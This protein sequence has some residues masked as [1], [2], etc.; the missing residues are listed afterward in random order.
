M[1]IIYRSLQINETQKLW[2]MM[3]ELDNETEFMMYEPGEREIKAK[4][5]H[6]LIDEVK[7]TIKGDDFLLIA[8]SDSEIVGYIWAQKGDLN[9]ILH[10][11]Y[12]VVGIRENFRGKGIGTEFFKHLDKWAKEKQVTR[13]ELTVMCPNLSAKHL[14]EKKGFTI[15]GIRRNSML[16][17]GK[18]VDE[19][20]MAKLL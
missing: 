10:T 8:E 4:D 18:L 20:Y 5:I 3:N 17:N 15:E 6:P 16:V 11:A 14:Y 9:R 19:Y 12:I 1:G 2:N 13:L 7:K